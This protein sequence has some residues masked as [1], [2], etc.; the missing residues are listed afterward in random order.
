[1]FYFL[2]YLTYYTPYNQKK[3]VVKLFSNHKATYYFVILT[4]Q[5]K[6]KVKKELHLI[7]TFRKNLLA[8]FTNL[9]TKKSL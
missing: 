3:S 8:N 7:K 9:K 4:F 1:M 2:N 5:V 6:F